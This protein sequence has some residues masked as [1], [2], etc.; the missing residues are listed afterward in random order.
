MLGLEE[1]VEEFLFD[2]SV[3]LKAVYEVCSVC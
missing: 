2:G 3:L 1:R